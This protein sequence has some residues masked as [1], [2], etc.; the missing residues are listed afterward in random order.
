VEQVRRWAGGEQIEPVGR[1]TANEYEPGDLFWMGA[2]G[3]PGEY[4]V[5]V[6]NAS[7]G[8]ASFQLDISD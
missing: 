6:E 1:G 2:F 8:D 5:V 7:T 4:Y 3:T